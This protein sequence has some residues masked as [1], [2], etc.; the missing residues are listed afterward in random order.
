MS[1][2]YDIAR[3]RIGNFF[4]ADSPPGQ[5]WIAQPLRQILNYICD[6]TRIAGTGFP[7]DRLLRQHR[8]SPIVRPPSSGP[9][10]A[11][12]FA[13]ISAAKKGS[14]CRLRLL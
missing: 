13:M 3:R 10:R 6:G 7:K 14:P 4:P 8:S 1:V 2:A 5:T 11:R 12:I 9:P